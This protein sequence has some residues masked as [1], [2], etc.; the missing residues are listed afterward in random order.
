MILTTRKL[1]YDIKKDKLKDVK[2]LFLI[3]NNNL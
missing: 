1:C 2:E 3:V